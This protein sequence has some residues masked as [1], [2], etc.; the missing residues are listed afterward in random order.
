MSTEPWHLVCSPRANSSSFSTSTRSAFGSEAGP[1]PSWS[2]E[3]RRAVLGSRSPRSACSTAH[4]VGAAVDLSLECLCRRLARSQE[5]ASSAC[6]PHTA[7]RH[8]QLDDAPPTRGDAESGGGDRRT[9]RLLNSQSTAARLGSGAKAASL[10]AEASQRA[11]PSAPRVPTRS[12][13][14]DPHPESFGR[15]ARRQST[16]GRC[17]IGPGG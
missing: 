17:P 10:G 1:A 14:A 11:A 7:A 9:H 5:S 15:T 6:F 2:Q 12:A 16:R 4:A 13:P 8:T 3:C